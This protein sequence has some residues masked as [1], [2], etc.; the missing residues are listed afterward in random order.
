MMMM[1]DQM[2]MATLEVSVK[3]YMALTSALH[4]SS[5]STFKLGVADC[6]REVAIL[7]L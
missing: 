3:K 2:K 1:Y 7:E 5:P 6:R 4:T